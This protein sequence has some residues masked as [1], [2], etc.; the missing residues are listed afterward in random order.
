MVTLADG[1]RITEEEV[2]EEL[3]R[4]Q[5]DWQVFLPAS[6]Q[7]SAFVQD[8]SEVQL[9]HYLP[10][11]KIENLDLFDQLQL[12]QVIRIC[13]SANSLSDAGR[14][15]FQVSRTQ[16]NS[17]NDSHRLRMYLQKFGLKFENL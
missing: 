12:K 10:D 4:L 17:V 13:Q 15:L 16:R 8:N 7:S 2:N 1:G 6:N 11:E 9:S 14:K 3:L 5:R